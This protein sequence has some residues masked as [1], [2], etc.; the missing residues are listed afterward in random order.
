[1]VTSHS[2][3]AGSAARRALSCG[4]RKLA[5]KEEHQQQSS[6]ATNRKSLT[7]FGMFV[8]P[9]A[10]S[11]IEI[12]PIARTSSEVYIDGHYRMPTEITFATDHI[13]SLFSSI[14]P[15]FL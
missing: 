14:G 7:R 8:I 5:V 11:R 3:I 15:T 2:L 6:A 9:R 4:E 13:N 12:D 10:E 1:M